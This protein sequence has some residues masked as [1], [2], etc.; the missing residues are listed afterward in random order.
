[1]GHPA[2][3]ELGVRELV[4]DADASGFIAELAQGREDLFHLFSR[5]LE[6]LLLR[7]EVGPQ[8]D[9]SAFDRPRRSVSGDDRS[10]GGETEEV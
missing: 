1:M 8:G 9:E 6:A 4:Q 7:F 3:V 5:R 2:V 10:L